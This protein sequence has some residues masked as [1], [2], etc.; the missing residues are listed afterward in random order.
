METRDVN[1]YA[2]RARRR[3][4]VAQ[5]AKYAL[6]LGGIIASV[7]LLLLAIRYADENHVAAVLHRLAF[8]ALPVADGSETALPV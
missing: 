3:R 5:R 2:D 8:E 7:L 1:D 4:A 6:I